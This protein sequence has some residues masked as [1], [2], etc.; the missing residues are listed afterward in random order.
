MT[1]VK[2]TKK[3]LVASVILLALCFTSLVGTTFAWFTDSVTSGNNIIKSGNLDIVLEYW[4]GEKWIDAEG[5]TIPFV[6]ADGRAD[7]LWEPGCTYEMAPIRVRNE[8]SLNAK[9]LI[10]LNGINGDEKLMEVITLQNRVNNIPESV[11]NGSAGNQMSQF[12]DLVLPIMYGTP[13]GNV[14]FDWSLAGKGTV[15]PGTGHTDTSPEFTLFAHMDETAGNEYQNLS[16][17]NISI[18]VIATQQTYEKDSFGNNYDKNATFPNVSA[19]VSIP[20]EDVTKPVKL[21]SKGMNVEIPAEVINELPD[22]VT[23]VKVIYSTPVKTEN[24]ISFAYVELV[25]QN[26]NRIDLENN[27]NEI[28]V[29]LPAQNT[30]APGTAVEIYHDGE[31]I[32]IATVAPDGTI[33]YTAIH[34][35]E[36]DV[37]LIQDAY[38]VGTAEDFKTEVSL[39]GIVIPTVDMTL[40]NYLVSFGETD[41]YLNGKNL[42]AQN[43]FLFVA[44][45][46]GAEL[47]VNGAGTV[48]TGTGH[49]GYAEKGGVLTVN[50]GTFNLGETN[51]KAHFYTQNSGK[52]VINGGTFISNDANTPI[53]YCINGFIEINGGFF[54]N[55]ANSNQALL[56]MGNNLNYINNQKITISG[57]TFVNWNP[58]D[59]AFASAW[60]NPDVPALIVLADG[61]EMISEIQENGDVWYTVVPVAQAQ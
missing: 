55:T 43:N 39:G 22:D 59:S 37:T 20:A 57:G 33:S 1:N 27:T 41:I 3:A 31:Q 18:T 42:V 38:Y 24:A 46:T 28:K 17:E 15:T 36:V 60:T 61:Y 52:T 19:P 25:D 21:S 9:I 50:G 10:L 48:T 58:M 16:I 12:E 6:A 51:N 44:P 14:I 49:A 53:L 45:A 4:D 7:I 56:S 23:S 35:C 47:S 2:S 30:F 5:K 8:G 11:L 26:N 13:D 29:M 40:T 34:F 32:A 54:Q